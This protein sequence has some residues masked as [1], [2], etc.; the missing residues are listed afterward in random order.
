MNYDEWY[1]KYSRMSAI[2]D[3]CRSMRNDR[4]RKLCAESGLDPTLLGIHPHNAMHSLR[5]GNPWP[6]IDYSK[7]RACLREL[8]HEFDAARIVDAWDKRVR[9]RARP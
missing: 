7:V 8:A 1:A 5:D 4:A 2:A 6:R 9:T 3:R